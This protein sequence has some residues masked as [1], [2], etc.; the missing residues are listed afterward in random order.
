MFFELID[1]LT[2]PGDV[3]KPNE[4]SSAH[5]RTM[6]VVVDGATGLS[7]SLMPGPSDAQWIARF[8][9]RRLCAHSDNGGD[10]LEWLRAA[11]FDS[12]RSFSALRYRE[13][14]QPFELPFASLMQAALVDGALHF[15][16]FGD[17]AAL[18]RAP[19][20]TFAMIGDTIEARSREAARARR[21]SP[22]P[23]ASGVREE[24][25]PALR[26]SRNRVNSE[27]GDWLFAP[28]SR[29]AEHA[30]QATR[31]A[32]PSSRLLIASDGFLALAADY[33]RYSTEALLSAA[34]TRG[35]NALGEE[36]RAIEAGD[37]EGRA[38]PRFKRS[39]DATALLLSIAG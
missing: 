3:A 22:T 10:P 20:G 35:L 31:P 9:A 26:A 38:Y 37:P 8:A 19:S 5:T 17:C 15:A 30:E 12:E 4:D 24:F 33:G 18:L 23:A 14:V 32:V 13:P 36:L 39:D 25:L 29:C 6:A 1:S 7:E 21:A 27:G 11:A 2:L 16:W 28:D 34:E